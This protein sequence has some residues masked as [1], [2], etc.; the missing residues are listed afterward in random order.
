MNVQSTD[1]KNQD[2][3]HLFP[4]AHLQVPNQEAWQ[5]REGPISSASDSGV[6]IEYCHRDVWIHA[7]SFAARVLSPEVRGWQALEEENE[8]EEG[9]VDLSDDEDSPNDDLVN[10]TDAEAE[11]HDT[12]TGFDSHVGDD[13]ERLA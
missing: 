12:N 5:D 11:K 8:E 3:G 13:V 10:R 6:A 7:G 2:H 4:P 1:S 9:A